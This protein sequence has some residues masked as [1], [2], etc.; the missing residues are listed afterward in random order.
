M[1][2]VKYQRICAQATLKH[3]SVFNQLIQWNGHTYFGFQILPLKTPIHSDS[4]Q[5]YSLNLCS[6][7]RT[8]RARTYTHIELDVN[9]ALLAQCPEEKDECLNM[10]CSSSDPKRRLEKQME[11]RM[12]KGGQGTQENT[13]G[14]PP[15]DSFYSWK[16]SSP[17]LPQARRPG[18]TGAI[19]SSSKAPKS[20]N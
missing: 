13:T 12:K 8:A 16:M 10:L 20:C 4:I 9:L 19:S 11:F 2:F 5:N 1:Y 18:S 6:K 7:A 3:K 14:D 15:R 17:F